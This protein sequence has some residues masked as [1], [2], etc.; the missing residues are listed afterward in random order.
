M[1]A[2]VVGSTEDP[3]ATA[4][5]EHVIPRCDRRLARWTGG[6]REVRLLSRL[7]AVWFVPTTEDLALGAR[8]FRCDV[9]AYAAQTR[10]A[11]LPA[12]TEGL[13]DVGDALDR[14]GLC[15]RGSPEDPDSIPVT[16]DRPHG[17]RAFTVQPLAPGPGGGY[18]LRSELSA[19]RTACS[20]SVREQLGFPLE[21]TY[22]WQPPSRA[23]WDDGLRHGFCWI[24]ST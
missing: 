20:D 21:W 16:C 7:H 8:W 3:D 6:T 11:E 22:G 24:Q 5:A 4:I 23:S 2:A 12:S 18:P 14:V 10:L 19:A 13:L 15:S 17:W 1:P 9:V